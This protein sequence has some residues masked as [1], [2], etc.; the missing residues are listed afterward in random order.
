MAVVATGV[1]GLAYGLSVHLIEA[2][3][4]PLGIMQPQ[5]LHAI[6]LIGLLMLIAAW[7]GILFFRR[8]ESVSAMPDWVLKLYVRSLNAGQPH[9]DTVTA[10][11]NHYAYR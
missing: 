2:A 7:L 3:V 4:T 5:P 8:P 9:P 6:Y 11:R 1:M 10:H